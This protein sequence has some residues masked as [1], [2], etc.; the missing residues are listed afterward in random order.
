M[1]SQLQI[2]VRNMD[3]SMALD[4]HIRQKA[5]KLE[6]FFESITSCRVVAEAPHKHQQHGRLYTV[7]LDITVPGREIVVNRDHAE[8]IYVALC[9]AFSAARRQIEDHSQVRRGETRSGRRQQQRP[10]A[11]RGEGGDE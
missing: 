8:D 6:Q 1:Q 10:A 3:H 11:A 5:A 2:S 4:H 7:R 9:D